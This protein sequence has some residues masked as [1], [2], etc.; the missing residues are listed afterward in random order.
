MLDYQ[1]KCISCQ[2]SYESAFNRY[3][4]DDCGPLKGTLEVIYDYEHIQWT[5]HDV[6]GSI[7]QFENL[8]P[9][10]FKT[11]MDD[12]VGGTPLVRKKDWYGIE[13]VLLKYDGVNVSGSYKDRATIIALNKAIE[14]GINTVFCASTGNAASSLALLGAYTRMQVVIFV[15]SSAPK[16]KLTQ[17]VLSG[18]KVFALDGTYDEAYDLSLEIGLKKGWYCRNSAINPYLLEG[19]KTGAFEVFI[20]YNHKV[21]DY[22]IVPVGDGT[23]LSGICKG[24]MELRKLGLIQKTPKIIGVQP[25]N[26]D[27]IKRVY[28]QG[29]PYEPNQR[30]A[31]SVADSICVG[32]PR[33]VIKACKYMEALE[34]IFLTVED[35]DILEAIQEMTKETGLFPEPA[36]AVPLAA[37]KKMANSG[38]IKP[39]ESVCL[40]VTGNGLKDPDAAKP[41]Q[42]LHAYNKEEIMER[43][44]RMDYEF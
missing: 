20:Q 29:P 38:I 21:P 13:E 37:L 40:F 1:L 19:K 6:K 34:G 36:G 30:Q 39:T 10:T 35:A 31:S 22:C 4:C 7:K 25:K 26:A 33:D 23:V 2:K 44:E 43:L 16:N 12:Y 15:P 8:L 9:V 3:F 5:A 14:Y 28:E 17:L 42:P 18:A 32:N 24:F 41:D 27:T 11:G